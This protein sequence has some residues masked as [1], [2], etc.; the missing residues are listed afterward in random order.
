MTPSAPRLR[1]IDVGWKADGFGRGEHTLV[2]MFKGPAA[3][4]SA[5]VLNRGSE[6]EAVTIDRLRPNT[7][8]FAAVWNRGGD[9]QI[10]S[11]RRVTSGP[12][13]V[14]KVNVPASGLVALSTRSLG[15]T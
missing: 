1:L 9:G 5:V 15:L 10:H 12:K 8:Y 4:Q 13:G 11:R 3:G 6:L 2:S 7:T 14:A